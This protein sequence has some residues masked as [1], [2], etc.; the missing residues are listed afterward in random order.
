VRTAAG[1]PATIPPGPGSPHVPAQRSGDAS[2]LV[3][4]VQVVN[5]PEQGGPAVVAPQ[6]RGPARRSVVRSEPTRRLQPG[7][8]ICGDCGEGNLPTRSFC[9]RCGNSLGDAETVRARWWRR[10]IPRRAP[11]KAEPVAADSPNGAAATVQRRK[12]KRRIFPLIRRSV[13]VVVLVAGVAYAAVPG[14]RAW[15]TPQILAGR[16]WAQSLIFPQYDPVR[17]V[18][19]TALPVDKK[20]PGVAAVDG[21]TNTYW[22]TPVTGTRLLTL[23][24]QDPVELRKALIRGGIVGDLRA[25]QRPHTLHLVYPTGKTQDLKLQDHTDPQEFELD[26][27]GPVKTIEVYVQDMYDNATSKQVTVTEIELFVQR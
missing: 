2:A 26:S 14:V 8:L 19:A 4:P 16:Q 3:Q 11:R 23:T 13:A 21:F 27:G 20:H 15:A 18:T 17:A 6:E 10:L 25:S 9:S 24:F 5:R 22:S 7:D 1:A 12:H